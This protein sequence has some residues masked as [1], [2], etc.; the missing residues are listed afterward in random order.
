[1]RA[2]RRFL[3]FALALT[4][5]APAMADTLLIE[6]SRRAKGAVPERGQ[7]MT[8]VEAQF[9]APQ[10]RRGP[11]PANPTKKNP[12]ISTWVYPGFTVYF[13]HQR[14]INTVLNRS[15]AHEIGPKP[16]PARRDG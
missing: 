7:S 16:V 12:P 5:A 14:V 10:E 15:S 9:G 2:M 13:E 4:L 3:A 1:M 11:V 8:Q 6:R